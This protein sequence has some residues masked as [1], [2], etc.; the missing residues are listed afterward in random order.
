MILILEPW[1]ASW[2][3]PCILNLRVNL[4]G[5]GPHHDWHDDPRRNF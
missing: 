1:F 2:T 5:I 3:D 4:P